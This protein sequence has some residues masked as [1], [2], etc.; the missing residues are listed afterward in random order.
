[1]KKII[2][3]CLSLLM[4]LSLVGCGGSS[5]NSNSSTS[6]STSDSNTEEITISP[7]YVAAENDDF[8]IEITSVCSEVNNP[9]VTDMEYISYRINYTVTNNSEYNID[10]GLSTQDASIGSTMV[11]VSNA[12]QNTMA[13]K[14]NSNAAWTID[15]ADDNCKACINSEGS[16]AINSLDDLL[17]FNAQLEVEFISKENGQNVRHKDLSVYVDIDLSQIPESSIQR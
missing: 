10:T 5:S 13:G 8:K 3:L 6:S 4:S 17:S 15:K 11:V 2:N 12:N 14:V 16:E 7:A 9:G 1:M